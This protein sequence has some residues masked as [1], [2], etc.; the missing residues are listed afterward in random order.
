MSAAVNT[1]APGEGEPATTEQARARFW[2]LT[3]GSIGVVYG[4]IGTSPLYAMREAL[5]HTQDGGISREELLGVTSLL[6]WALLFIVTAKYVLFLMRADNRGEG[7]TLSLMAL[8]QSALGRPTA[9]VFV[10]GV[11]G[12]ALFYGDALIT[13]AISV[14]SAVEGLRL[15]TPMFDHFVVP[16][17]VGILLLLFAAQRHGTGRV[18]ALFGPI[19]LV[20]F[21]A[22]ACA[23]PL[24]HRRRPGACLRPS[25]RC[26]R[27]GS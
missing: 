18:A 21:L 19:T 22:I 3:L 12:A 14:L 25:A 26:T 20:W 13:P 1:S 15:V 9:A 23:R 10:L 27:S 11:A 7:G 8:A 4:D 16:I 6:L 2:A 5:V 24:P 17:T